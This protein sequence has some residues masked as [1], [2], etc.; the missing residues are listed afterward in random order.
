MLE[1]CARRGSTSRRHAVADPRASWLLTGAVASAAGATRLTGAAQRR[2]SQT[3]GRVDGHEAEV[4]SRAPSLRPGSTNEQSD[5]SREHDELV[6][7]FPHLRRWKQDLSLYR[8]TANRSSAF[9]TTSPGV[10]LT[11][12]CRVPFSSEVFSS[13]RCVPCSSSRF[14]ERKWV[15]ISRSREW[16]NFDLAWTLRRCFACFARSAKAGWARCGSRITMGSRP[17]SS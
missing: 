16:K 3:N 7:R 15:R 12:P 8:R 2:G 4:A 5:P 11:R 9:D 6:A 17:K 13:D 10:A 1:P 14:S